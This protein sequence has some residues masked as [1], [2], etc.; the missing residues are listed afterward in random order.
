MHL[1][2][3]LASGVHIPVKLSLT[4]KKLLRSFNLRLH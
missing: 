4:D 3:A 1:C 2:G